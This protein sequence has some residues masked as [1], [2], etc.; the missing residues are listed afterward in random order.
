MNNFRWGSFV[1]TGPS[2]PIESTPMVASPAWPPWPPW[3]L[4]FELLPL[5]PPPSVSWTRRGSGLFCSLLAAWGRE[6]RWR[7]L[8]HRVTLARVRCAVGML[9]AFARLWA[10]RGPRHRRS[11]RFTAFLAHF[12]SLGLCARPIDSPPDVGLAADANC[13]APRSFTWALDGNPPTPLR[14]PRYTLATPAVPPS[15]YY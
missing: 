9:L 3:L 7:A 8:G 1:N 5:L 14:R 15:P 11:M 4:T 2:V 13:A 12:C 10:A 6:R